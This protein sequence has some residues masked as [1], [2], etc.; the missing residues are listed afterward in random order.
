MNMKKQEIMFTRY[1]E[2]MDMIS[3]CLVDEGKA[4]YKEQKPRYSYIES[5]R[6]FIK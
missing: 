4:E 5:I 6:M 2:M 3:C 1:G